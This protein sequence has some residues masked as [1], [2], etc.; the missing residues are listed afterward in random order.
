[1]AYTGR[2]PAAAPLTSGD[3]PD[4][5][6]TPNDLST[7]APSWDT[8]GNV[9]ATGTVTTDGASLDGAVVIN[10]SG[11]DVDFRIESDTNANAFFLEGSSGRVGIGTSNTGTGKTTIKL[12]GTDISGDTDGSTVGADAIVNLFNSSGGTTNNTVMLLGSTS[13]ST[14]GQIASG[15]GFTR[16]NGSNWGTQLRFYTHTTSTSDLDQLNE[17]MRIDS[18]GRVTMPYQPAFDAHYNTPTSGTSGWQKMPVW[19]ATQFNIGGHYSTSTGRFTAPVDGRYFFYAG[20]WCTTAGDG[21][22]FAMELRVNGT[23]R[24]VGG[25]QLSNDDSPAPIAGFHVEL[26]AGDYTEIWRYHPITITYISGSSTVYSFRHGGYLI[27]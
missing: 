16:E 7:G 14:V 25:I 2:T 4:G 24:I 5:S 8:S 9:T 27:G 26:N 22:R 19:P 6:V 20:G 23:A 17:V 10:E 18:S 13:E 21:T 15:I 11:A 1:M 12:S 3:I